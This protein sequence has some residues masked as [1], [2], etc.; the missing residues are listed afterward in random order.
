[1]LADDEAILL[2]APEALLRGDLDAMR[3]LARTLVLLGLGMTICDG[4]Y[5][6]SQGN[7]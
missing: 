4:S 2:D 7:T 6:A 3:A 5:P 1:M